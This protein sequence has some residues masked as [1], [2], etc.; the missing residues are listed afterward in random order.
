MVDNQSYCLHFLTTKKLFDNF[1][2]KF[3]YEQRNP[4]H[5]SSGGY[6][7]LIKLNF[8]KNLKF[9]QKYM[10]S[11]ISLEHIYIGDRISGSRISY[12][13]CIPNSI[14]QSSKLE[15]INFLNAFIQFSVSDFTFKY[16]WKN[17]S[18][19]IREAIDQDYTSFPKVNPEMLPIGTFMNFSVE[20]HF[21]N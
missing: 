20:W 3:N 13:E 14:E 7:K 4:Y 6:G 19:I 8:T 1:E 17:F 18:Q 16:E 9:F 10:S 21:D 5:Y 12:L 2:I 15:N 11:V